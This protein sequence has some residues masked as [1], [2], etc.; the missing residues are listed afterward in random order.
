MKSTRR[1]FLL[2]AS[3][4]VAGCGPGEGTI[5]RTVSGSADTGTSGSSTQSTPNTLTDTWSYEPGPEPPPWVPEGQEDEDAFP[6]GVQTGDA[7]LSSVVVSVRCYEPNLRMVLVRGVEDGWEDA[8]EVVDLLSDG[9]VVQIELEELV[10][11]TTYAVAFYADDGVRRSSP[12]RFRTALYPGATRVVRFGATS[13]LGGNHPWPTLTHASGELFDFFVLLGDTIYADWS[14]GGSGF[15]ENWEDALQITGMRDLTQSTSLAATWDDHE[16]ENNWDIDEPGV[17]DTALASLEAFRRAIPQRVGSQGSGLWRSMQW[18]DSVELFMLDCRGER[19]GGDYISQEQMDWLKDGLLNSTARFKIIAN[20]VPITDMSDVYFGI[21]AVDRWDGYAN[22]RDEILD[23][24]RDSNIRG[25]LWIA[26]DFHFGAL[27]HV[28]RPGSLHH[29]QYE[30]FCG[31]GGSDLNPVVW[32]L[33]P[34]DHYEQVVKE[35]NYVAFECDP[36]AGT[37][38]V[39]FIADDGGVIANQTLSV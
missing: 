27:A 18:G 12:S 21:D 16:V 19:F 37:I 32:L 23:H 11:D 25:V 22:Q 33:N 13:C 31:P 14:W 26:G 1:S 34:N 30:V 36:D 10:P 20:S 35:F 4:I 15:E 6:F 2:S 9:D 24:I 38:Q 5:F 8:G 39:A 7:R 3:A 29:F 17:L 28:G